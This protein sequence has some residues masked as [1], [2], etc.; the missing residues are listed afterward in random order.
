[1]GMPH[2]HSR[3]FMS[4]AKWRKLFSVVNVENIE[5]NCC[6]W[7]LVSEELPIKGYLPSSRALGES[8][9]GDCGALNGPFDYKEIEWLMI[10]RRI[11]WRAYKDAPESSRENNIQAILELISSTG[12]TFEI[13]STEEGL[14][15]YGYKP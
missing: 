4:D 11:T 6:D 7:K 8:F 14:R 13:E 12:S 2:K 15:V 9:V 1:M 10:P 5:V 3:S